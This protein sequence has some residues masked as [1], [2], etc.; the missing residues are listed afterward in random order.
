[1]TQVQILLSLLSGLVL[2][3]SCLCPIIIRSSISTLGVVFSS[4]L[5][6]L[7]NTVVEK[8]NHLSGSVI[9]KSI[10]EASFITFE[11]I[12]EKSISATF[13]NS[14]SIIVYSNAIFS[15]NL[16][17]HLIKESTGV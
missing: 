17:S 13:K 10:K 11:A 15:W 1:M 7:L 16:T 8:E 9:A 6:G 3:C 12:K 2:Q 14:A 4:P 5:W